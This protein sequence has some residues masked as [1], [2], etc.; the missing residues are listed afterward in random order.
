MFLI[1]FVVLLLVLSIVQTVYIANINS[2]V[3]QVKGFIDLAASTAAVAQ[4]PNL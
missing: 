2:N 3:N 4:N 1:V